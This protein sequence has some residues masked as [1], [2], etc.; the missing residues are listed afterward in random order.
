MAEVKKWIEETG[1]AG[2]MLYLEGRI[3]GIEENLIPAVAER[4]VEQ[5]AIMELIVEK[6][7]KLVLQ[8]EQ[9]NAVGEQYNQMLQKAEHNQRVLEKRLLKIGTLAIELEKRIIELENR[10]RHSL[11]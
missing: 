9:I 4:M 6:V 10:A 3:E 5:A 1:H 8:K 2:A 7:A 11:N